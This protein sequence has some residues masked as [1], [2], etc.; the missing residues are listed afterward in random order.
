MAVDCLEDG[1]TTADVED[2]AA[3]VLVL[4]AITVGKHMTYE[5]IDDRSK[6]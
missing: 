1:D 5:Y 6:E 4:V 3:T 2:L